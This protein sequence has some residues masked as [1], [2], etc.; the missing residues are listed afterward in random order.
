MNY[1][2]VCIYDNIAL[3]LFL[4]TVIFIKTNVM[5]IHRVGKI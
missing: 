1:M 5:Y 3:I 2:Y 4:A